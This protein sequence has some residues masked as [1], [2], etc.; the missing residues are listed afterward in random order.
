MDV[1]KGRIYDDVIVLGSGL[2]IL[3]LTEQEIQYINRCKVVIAFN[4][5]MIFYKKSKIIPTHVYFLDFHDNNLQILKHLLN[6]CKEDNLDNLTFILHNRVKDMIFPHYTKRLNILFKDFDLKKVFKGQF[7]S[8]LRE[9]K[10]IVLFKAATGPK[11]A[12]YLFTSFNDWLQ[13]G[14]WAKTIAQ[15]LYHYRGSLSSVLNYVTI[16]APGKTVYLVGTDFNSSRY[17]F[18]KE[19]NDLPFTTRDWTSDIIK[20]HNKHFSVIEYQGTTIFD[21]IPYILYEMKQH[22]NQ[23]FCINNKSEMVLKGNITLKKLPL[24]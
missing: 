21:K 22:G 6:V 3:E 10:D 18:D 11:K 2:S 20:E 19:L 24:D 5:F 15:S 7:I 23:L 17:F 12:E 1:R 4:K 9:L 8:Y 14:E 16:I 13:G